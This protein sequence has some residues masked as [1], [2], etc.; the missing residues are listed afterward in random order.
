MMLY[1]LQY[2]AISLGVFVKLFTIPFTQESEPVDTFDWIQFRMESRQ[3]HQL[4][5]FQCN[6]LLE[7]CQALFEILFF[8]QHLYQLVMFFSLRKKLIEKHCQRH[9]GPES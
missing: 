2:F 8:L 5:S 4:C 6:T 9:N 7:Q 1:V 3:E